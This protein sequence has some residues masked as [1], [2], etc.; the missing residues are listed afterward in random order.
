MNWGLPSVCFSDILIHI[1]CF[2][3]LVNDMV[4]EEQELRKQ[5]EQRVVEFSEKIDKL[6]EE[7]QLPKFQ[8]SHFSSYPFI[9]H[10]SC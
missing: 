4:T 1:I 5:V 2:L 7:L 10:S 8:V 3:D 9:L 6:T